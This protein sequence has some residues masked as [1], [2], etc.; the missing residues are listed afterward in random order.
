M[1]YIYALLAILVIG[2][3]WAAFMIGFM[4]GRYTTLPAPW[5]D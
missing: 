1:E 5:D 3:L 4:I 2:L